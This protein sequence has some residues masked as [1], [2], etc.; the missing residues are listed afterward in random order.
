[1][2]GGGGDDLMFGVLV[3]GVFVVVIGD[4]FVVEQV[5]DVDV[6]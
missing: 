3:V 4:I 1:M 5:V 2:E 6:D